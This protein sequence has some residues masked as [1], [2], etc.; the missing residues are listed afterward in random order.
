MKFGE[1]KKHLDSCL[2]GDRFC[3]A[4]IVTGDD[5]YLVSSAIKSFKGLVDPEYADFNL[6]V[7]SGDGAVFPAIDAAYTFPVFD[8]R[9]VVVLGLENAP[10]ESEKSA[11]DKYVSEPSETTVFVISCDEDVAKTVKSKKVQLVD[12]SKL[13]GDEL[14]KEITDLCAATP[15]VAIERGA[16]SELIDR[17]QGN[18]SRIVSEITKLKSRHNHKTRRMRHGECG[19]RFSD[20]RTCKRRERKECGQG[21]RSA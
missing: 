1:L 12:C 3:A 14:V 5:D 13:D 19:Y 2:S 9:K 20:I 7:V 11:L 10:S 8:E 17:T 15:S 4:Y 6:S 16:M 21:N 18:M